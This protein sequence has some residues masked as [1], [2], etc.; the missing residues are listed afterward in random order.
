MVQLKLSFC[1]VEGGSK[2]DKHMTAASLLLAATLAQV[3]PGQHKLCDSQLVFHQMLAGR[4]IASPPRAAD[5][6]QR[7][8]FEFGKAMQN[9]I[10]LVGD[11]VAGECVVIDGMYD[12]VG[13]EA[14]ADAVGCNI[15]AFVAT[16]Y[17]YDHIG[18]RASST[19]QPAAPAHVGELPGLAYFLD[20]GMPGYIHETEVAL[21]AAQIGVDA[22][23][24][25]PLAEDDVVDV[26]QV[27]LRVVHTPGH[28][29]G[30]VV[31][32]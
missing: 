9:L 7:R 6:A 5:G 2:T 3:D 29:P 13:I 17:H 10:Y 28:S 25:T 24:L 12:P 11:P 23:V 4:D 1:A 31:L 27:K 30:S 26:G 19:V 14:A 16:H 15:T 22:A 20:K 32:V 8:V 21:A 18:S